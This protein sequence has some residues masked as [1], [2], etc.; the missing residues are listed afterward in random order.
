MATHTQVTVNVSVVDNAIVCSP[1]PVDVTSLDSRL[2]FELPAQGD[3]VFPAHGAIVISDPGAQF[4]YGC[5]RVGE[6]VVL[7]KDRNTAKGSYKYTVNV[8]NRVNGQ[9]LSL[10]PE[11]RNEAR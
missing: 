10:D 8:R 7:L 4:P 9:A 6:R 11:I 5:H 1:D 2:R 3:W